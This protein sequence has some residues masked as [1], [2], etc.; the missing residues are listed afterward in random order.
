MK[1]RESPGSQK[2]SPTTP[3]KESGQD[4]AATAAGHCT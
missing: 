1:N 2:Y 3:D 4:A